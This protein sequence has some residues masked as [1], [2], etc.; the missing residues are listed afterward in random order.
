[1]DEVALLPIV[2]AAEARADSL[3]RLHP[4]YVP[5][6][7]LAR[8]FLDG[9]SLQL[10]GGNQELFAFV[11]DMNRLFERFVFRFLGRHR[12]A[13]LPSEWHD[14]ALRPQSTGTVTHLAHREG[15]AVFRLEP[16]IALCRPDGSLPLLIDTKYKQLDDRARAG[17]VSQADM[18]Q[19]YAYA[20]RYACPRILLLYPQT[21]GM[22]EPMR[23]RFTLEDGGTI[24]AATLD[25]R[26]ELGKPEGIQ[27]L[28]DELRKIIKEE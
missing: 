16:D 18:Y 24:E 11:F 13:I 21:S 15:R 27:Q 6:L 3:T 20:H 26:V 7:N 28:I 2:T 1:M 14:C 12:T 10:S 9:G 5:L 23:V 19:M 17:G 22:T 4:A 25:L 8:L